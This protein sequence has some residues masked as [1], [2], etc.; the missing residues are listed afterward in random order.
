[1][2]VQLGMRALAVSRRG[3]RAGAP[4][5]I[6]CLFVVAAAAA[7]SAPRIPS[8]PLAVRAV[9]FLSPR[10]GST[11]VEVLGEI[12]PAQLMPRTPDRYSFEGLVLDARGSELDRI[13]F[14]RALP[15]P[16]AAEARVIESFS[17]VAPPGDLRI[18]VRVTPEGGETAQ[19][20]IRLAALAPHQRHSD[21]LLVTRIG[22]AD[23]DTAALESGEV[24][25]AGLSMFSGPAPALRQDSA[26]LSFYMELYTDSAAMRIQRRTEVIGSDGVQV[27]RTPSVA[28]EIPANGAVTRGAIDLTGLPE[29]DYKL[30]VIL[31]L[32]DTTIFVEAPF[33]V[34]PW[35]PAAGTGGNVGALRSE[36]ALFETADSSSLDSLYGPLVHLLEPHER[37]V[38]SGLTLA[39]R[40]RFLIAFWERRDPTS[41]TP[42]NP[43]MDAFYAAVEE[44]N[45]L[46]R[47]GRAA[48]VPG[49]RTDRGRIFLRYGP[50]DEQLRRP[51]AS[52]RPY[53]AWRYTRGRARNYVFYDQSGL[54][55]YFLLATNDPTEQGTR[56]WDQFVRQPAA[57]IGSDEVRRLFE[58]YGIPLSPVD[59]S[60]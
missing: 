7:F 13:A 27:V 4:R 40:R 60:P 19:Q 58:F 32:P 49:W 36:A 53:E 52:P 26:I 46:F 10:D 9:R 56:S 6:G 21:L 34:A 42:D 29:G 43:A 48:G 8:Q 25:R 45:L 47:E 18:V 17:F 33:E 55:N 23:S 15:R 22:T 51:M 41:A 14:S 50:P 3:T 20:E 59:V 2:F 35:N 11:R 12:R 5:L 24:R 44:A 30:R 28:L 38:Y 54:G 31:A 39:G 1:M 37:S 16:L 57:S